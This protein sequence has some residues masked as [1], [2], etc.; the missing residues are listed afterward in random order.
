MNAYDNCKDQ[1]EKI[2]IFESQNLCG[3]NS[4]EWNNPRITV[5]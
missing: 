3:E 5:F 4:V 1:N 2:L